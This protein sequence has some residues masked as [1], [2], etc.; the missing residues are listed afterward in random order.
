MDTSLPDENRER[1]QILCQQF[2]DNIGKPG[3]MLFGWQKDDGTYEVVQST[4]DANPI[5][6]VK[7]V[8]WYMQQVTKDL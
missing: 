5:A 7:A 1:I 8:T 4:K 2:L 3:F 6:I